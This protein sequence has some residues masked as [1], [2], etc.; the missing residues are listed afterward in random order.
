M[1]LRYRLPDGYAPVQLPEPVELATRFGTYRLAWT[2]VDRELR[3]ERAR[4]LVTPRIEPPDYREFRE[5]LT[6]A[7]QADRQVVVVRRQEGQ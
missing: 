1:R 6:T 4:D 2:W 7:D 5:F 3:V